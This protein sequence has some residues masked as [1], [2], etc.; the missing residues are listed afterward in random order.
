MER[1]FESSSAANSSLLVA[2]A[3]I[4]IEILVFVENFISVSSR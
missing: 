3:G 4:T 2:T 1:Y